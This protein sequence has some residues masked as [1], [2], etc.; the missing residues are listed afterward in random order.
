MTL[1]RLGNSSF[2][3]EGE[4]HPRAEERI[5]EFLGSYVEKYEEVCATACKRHRSLIGIFECADDI[6]YEATASERLV[7]FSLDRY[8]VVTFRNA[9]AAPNAAQRRDGL[10][11]H[12]SIS[13]RPTQ[14]ECGGLTYVLACGSKRHTSIFI[15][16]S[17]G[18]SKED[19]EVEAMIK[20]V[21][22]FH[23]LGHVSDIEKGRNYRRHTVDPLKAEVYAHRFACRA[24]IKDKYRIALGWYLDQLAEMTDDEAAV[25]FSKSRECEAYQREISPLYRRGQ[26]TA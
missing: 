5:D 24:M 15:R 21:V 3:R 23:E 22:L 16:E 8:S 10:I 2:P 12:L 1:N 17:I 19:S 9:R 7:H 4:L 11:D 13:T 26:T 25:R 18:L 14:T 6:F 20:L